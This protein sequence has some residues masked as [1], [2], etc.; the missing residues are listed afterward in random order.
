MLRE[1][2]DNY[3]HILSIAEGDKVC[4]LLLEDADKKERLAF[5]IE[6]DELIDFIK[7]QNHEQG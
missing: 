6:K 2:I 4:T 7:G 1:L 3:G 5:H